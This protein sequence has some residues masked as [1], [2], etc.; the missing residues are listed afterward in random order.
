[1]ESP[2]LTKKYFPMHGSPFGQMVVIREAPFAAL[3]EVS[4]L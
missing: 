1:M 3:P 4:P 2:F